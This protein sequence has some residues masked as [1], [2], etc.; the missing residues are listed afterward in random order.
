MGFCCSQLSYKV[1]AVSNIAP[2]YGLST[3]EIP[4]ESV[5]KSLTQRGTAGTAILTFSLDAGQNQYQY[6]AYPVAY[7]AVEFHDNDSNFNGG[8]D[9]AHNDPMSVYGPVEIDITIDGQVIPFY[10]YRTDFPALG[11]CHWTTIGA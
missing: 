3:A 11:L 6:F 2:F 4:S 8:W 7:G 10:V 9:G 5:V 1:K